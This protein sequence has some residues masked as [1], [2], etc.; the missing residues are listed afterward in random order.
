M[1]AKFDFKNLKSWQEM[2]LWK[3]KMLEKKNQANDQV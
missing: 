1:D 3:S 2:R